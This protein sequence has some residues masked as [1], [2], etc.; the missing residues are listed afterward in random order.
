MADDTEEEN[1]EAEGGEEGEEE[2]GKKKGG[3][4]KLIIF[5]G[6]PVIIVLLG[7]VAGALFFLGGG[8]EEVVAEGEHHGEAHGDG[9]DHGDGHDSEAA[10]NA[11]FDHLDKREF[12][13]TVNIANSNGRS[14][15]MMIEFAIV[16][17]D[18]H[19]GHE[20]DNELIQLRLRDAMNEFMRTL[21]VEDLDGSM[22]NFRM[23]AEMLR[24]TNLILD[25]AKA[26]DLL[27]LSL[28]MG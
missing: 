20:L 1:P 19:V 17:T 14:L 15:S 23:R 18:E 4:M 24:R 22:G 12:S 21:R 13:M 9:D 16:F 2:E 3:L 11:Y 25:P 6:L 5:V 10:T 26:E 27:I 28:V 7:G 8:E